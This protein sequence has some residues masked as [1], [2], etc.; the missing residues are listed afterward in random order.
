MPAAPAA[1]PMRNLFMAGDLPVDA[2]V[3]LSLRYP[4]RGSTMR[5]PWVEVGATML[6]GGELLV[7]ASDSRDR[8]RGRGLDCGRHARVVVRCG[9]RVHF[10]LADEHGSDHDH[11]V[12][13]LAARHQRHRCRSRA[14]GAGGADRDRS[15]CAG[16]VVA[17]P[18]AV[19]R[20][21][22]VAGR[23][24][25][26]RGVGRP[27][28]PSGGGR[29]AGRRS[30][31]SARCGQRAIVRLKSSWPSISP[32]RMKPARDATASDRVFAGSI[33]RCAVVNA[34]RRVRCSSSSC[35]PRVA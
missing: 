28:V 10:C 32:A 2:A 31:H 24:V 21:R 30:A 26:R 6:W 4:G 17:P 16:F 27:S 35:N 29:S 8:P 23:V 25:A 13:R 20:W 18:R 1:A 9:R 5:H 22:D 33:S 14:R 11:D 34:V 7:R 3:F 19:H 12:S 15:R